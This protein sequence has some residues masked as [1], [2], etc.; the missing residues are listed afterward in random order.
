MVDTKD[1]KSFAH[2]VRGGS[3][4]PAGT[5]YNFN[6]LVSPVGKIFIRIIEKSLKNSVI[7]QKV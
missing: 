5:T 1:S 6:A 4:P 7:Y 3:S 2:C